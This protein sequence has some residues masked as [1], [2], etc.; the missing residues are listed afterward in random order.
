MLP[1]RLVSDDDPC[2]ISKFLTLWCK[3][4]IICK[5][6]KSFARNNIRLVKFV[7]EHSGFREVA[8]RIEDWYTDGGISILIPRIELSLGE[9]KTRFFFTIKLQ[10]AVT[11]C[12]ISLLSFSKKSHI[13]WYT[14]S[15]LCYARNANFVNLAAI[16]ESI[17]PLVDLINAT[18]QSKQ[19]IPNV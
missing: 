12:N 10:C 11:L 13:S 16:I 8:W 17:L 4:R 15:Y 7:K 9:L 14:L 6:L 1:L 18:Q 5:I 19:T 3:T 2:K